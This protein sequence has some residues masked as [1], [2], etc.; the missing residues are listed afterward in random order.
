MTKR[1]FFSE[2]RIRN[3]YVAAALC[4]VIVTVMPVM[5]E[6]NYTC[7][8]DGTLISNGSYWVKWDTIPE[9]AIGDRL[10]INGTTNLS[11]GT[12]IGYGLAAGVYNVPKRFTPPPVFISGEAVVSPGN[13]TSNS[14][15]LSKTVPNNPT[16]N[17]FFFGFS[18][19]K[20]RSQ[21]EFDAFNSTVTG[22]PCNLGF[23]LADK[24]GNSTSSNLIAP[25]T[26]EP[27]PFSS[28]VILAYQPLTLMLIVLL[29]LALLTF[30]FVR[31]K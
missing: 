2:S 30:W 16:N 21:T 27:M 6:L 15:S 8:A 4:I 28:L 20:S 24:A 29:G 26:N 31:R 22:G 14:I 19:I 11:A 5:A 23:L 7:M 17:Y 9:R 1:P 12:I 10:F 3:L 25:A 13:G 18:V